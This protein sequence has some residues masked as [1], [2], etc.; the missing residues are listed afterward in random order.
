MLP[1]I[2]D[3]I[4]ERAANADGHA[5]EAIIGL[6]GSA[7]L[8]SNRG[9]S[10]GRR[11]ISL[12]LSITM[13]FVLLILPSL[14]LVIAFSYQENA[15]N[16]H[17]LSNR[18]IDRVRDEAIAMTTNFLE[19]VGATLRLVAEMAGAQPAFFRSEESR[20]ILHQALTAITAS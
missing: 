2:V 17:S 20:N 5:V 9:M 1:G 11:E 4:E 3:E 18:F 16:L 15:R 7:T 12:Q 6:G 19:P 10:G 14:G 13:L 8:A